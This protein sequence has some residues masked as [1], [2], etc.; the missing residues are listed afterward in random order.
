VL[1]NAVLCELDAA[2]RTHGL[3]HLRWVDD[4]VL[5]APDRG[6]HAAMDLIATTLDGLRLRPNDAKTRIVRPGEPF[7]SMPSRL[8]SVPA[9][10]IGPP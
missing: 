6:I 1:A 3:R 2:I 4:V 9:A 7:V 10:I 5:A 8:R